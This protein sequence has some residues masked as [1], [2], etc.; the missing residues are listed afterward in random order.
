MPNNFILLILFIILIS[1]IPLYISEEEKPTEAQEGSQNNTE[2][3]NETETEPPEEDPF[4]KFNFTNIITLDDSNYTEEIKKY[5]ELYVLFY[6][7][8][9]GH[10][11]EFIPKFIQAAEYY[12]EEIPQLLFIRIDGSKNENPSV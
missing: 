2:L 7:P 3:F 8:W 1:F 11:H 12:N 9:C 6:A 5:E 10:C 4:N